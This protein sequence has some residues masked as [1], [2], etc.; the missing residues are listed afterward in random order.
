MLCASKPEVILENIQWKSAPLKKT[1]TKI[2][3]ECLSSS[4]INPDSM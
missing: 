3:T 1:F 4:H 2:P